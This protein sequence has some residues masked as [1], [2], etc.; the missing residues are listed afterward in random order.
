MTALWVYLALGVVFGGWHL[1][2]RT[3]MGFPANWPDTIL[4]RFLL[5]PVSVAVL[6]VFIV[7]AHRERAR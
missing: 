4:V 6:I 3:L 5:W 1:I 7:Q 2:G